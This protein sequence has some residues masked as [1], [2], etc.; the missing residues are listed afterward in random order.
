MGMQLVFLMDP[1]DPIDVEADTT[2]VLMLEGQRRGHTLWMA[3][4]EHLWVEGGS[5]GVRATRVQ[6][7]KVP[8]E[9]AIRFE[10]KDLRLDA[11]DAVFMRKDPPF[12]TDYYVATLLLDMVDRSRVVLVNDPQGLRDFNEKLAALRWADFMPPSLVTADRDRLRSF[13]ETHGPV[14]VKPLLNAGGEG[15]IRLERGD[16]NT[17][18]VL[19]LLTRFGTR[20]I[21]AQKFV[22]AVEAGDKRILLIDGE[23][24]GAINRVPAADDVRANMHVGGRAE[25]AEL[26]ERDLQLCRALKDELVARGLLLVGIDVIGGFLTEVNVTSPTGLQELARFDG[27]H[28]ERDVFDAVEQRHRALRTPGA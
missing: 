23:P 22:P 7:Q 20:M 21:E 8:G 24:R 17:R 11:Q 6:V 19:D 13:V 16:K 26:T 1:I 15:I 4:P 5:V 2:L 18:S 3:Q 25:R 28:L 10:T 27:V 12:D 9:P 14:V